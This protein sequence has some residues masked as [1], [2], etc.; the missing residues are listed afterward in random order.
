M[1][2]REW[3]FGLGW[4]KQTLESGCILKIKLIRHTGALTVGAMGE[5]VCGG[6]KALVLNR[7]MESHSG[8][9]ACVVSLGAPIQNPCWTCLIWNVEGH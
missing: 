1:G 7:R 5:S 6:A 8:T 9:G 4:W 2:R 3:L